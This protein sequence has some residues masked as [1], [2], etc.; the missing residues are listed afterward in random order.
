MNQFE[1][2]RR[3]LQRYA[4]AADDRDIDALSALFHPQAEILGSRGTLGVEEWLDTMHAPVPFPTA[5]TSSVT[6]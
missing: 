4:R 1:E 5:C 2:L 6:H 3:L